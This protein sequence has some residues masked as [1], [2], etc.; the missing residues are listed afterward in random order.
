MPNPRVCCRGTRRRRYRAGKN[1]TRHCLIFI[2]A[3]VVGNKSPV[4]KNRTRTLHGFG[5]AGQCATIDGED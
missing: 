1:E 2:A 5:G 4:I 3:G